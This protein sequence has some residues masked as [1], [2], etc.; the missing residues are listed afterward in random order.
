MFLECVLNVFF[1]I[2][3]CFEGFWI[4]ERKLFFERWLFDNKHS[5]HINVSLLFLTVQNMNSA[6]GFKTPRPHRLDKTI[7]PDRYPSPF[8]GWQWGPC[9]RP[10]I[11]AQSGSSG[12]S[13]PL[14]RS[15]VKSTWSLL[16]NSFNFS[17]S[18]VPERQHLSSLGLEPFAGLGQLLSKDLFLEK[19]GRVVF[20]MF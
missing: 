9:R 7:R 8:W 5:K 15:L 1:V 3:K 4:F 13:S 16:A 17:R 12:S 11:S 19:I 18:V 14:L 20:S 10:C 2:C 6:I